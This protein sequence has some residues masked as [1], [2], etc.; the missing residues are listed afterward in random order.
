[1]KG[2]PSPSPSTPRSVNSQHLSSASSTPEDTQFFFSRPFLS[3]FL[4][5]AYRLS[6]KRSVSGNC[7]HHNSVTWEIID[8]RDVRLPSSS[9]RDPTHFTGFSVT[10]SAYKYC[11]TAIDCTKRGLLVRYH[12]HPAR[13]PCTRSRRVRGLGGGPFGWR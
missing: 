4:Y 8:L 9:P 7:K 11:T 6:S 5:F 12:S 13:C 10:P 1:M 3:P 2:E